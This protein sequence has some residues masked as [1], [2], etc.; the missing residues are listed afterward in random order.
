MEKYVKEGK[1]T[2]RGERKKVAANERQTGSGKLRGER[3]KTNTADKDQPACKVSSWNPRW[4]N[5]TA[6]KHQPTRMV[7]SWNPRGERIEIRVLKY[8]VQRTTAYAATTLTVSTV[9]HSKPRCMQTWL[10]WTRQHAQLVQ[11]HFLALFHPKPNG[12]LHFHLESC[13]LMCTY[14]VVS[15]P[16]QIPPL[17]QARPMMLCIYTS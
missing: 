5:I 3:L 15:N 2:L 17:A 1:Q 11:K 9:F 14:T 6:E 4:N 12:Y 13:N 8:K 10:H 7:S 16:C